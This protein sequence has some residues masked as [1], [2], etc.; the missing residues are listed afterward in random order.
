MDEDKWSLPEI[1]CDQCREFASLTTNF[2]LVFHHAQL[3]ADCLEFIL[4]VAPGWYD[5]ILPLAENHIERIAGVLLDRQ[6]KVLA[7][8][9]EMAERAEHRRD[10]ALGVAIVLVVLLIGLIIWLR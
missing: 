5:T 4:M 1:T 6:K 8:K 9:L 3:C 2:P 7:E 10:M